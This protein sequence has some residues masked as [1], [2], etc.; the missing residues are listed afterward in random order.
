MYSNLFVC[1]DPCAKILSQYE[2]GFNRRLEEIGT[3]SV[4][5]WASGKTKIHHPEATRSIASKAI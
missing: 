5:H 3:K 4:I 2:N 1:E